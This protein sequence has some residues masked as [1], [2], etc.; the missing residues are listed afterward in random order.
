MIFKQFKLKNNKIRKPEDSKFEK[1]IN[2]WWNWRK[3]LMM[4]FFANQTKP[5]SKQNDEGQ[6]EQ[7]KRRKWSSNIK[8]IDVNN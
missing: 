2:K 1:A 4:K 7:K 3:L 8:Q 6:F 5:K